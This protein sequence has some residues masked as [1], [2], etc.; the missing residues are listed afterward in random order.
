MQIN[1]AIS[2][3]ILVSVH[4]SKP[5]IVQRRHNKENS[6]DERGKQ[7]YLKCKPLFNH[8][9]FLSTWEPNWSC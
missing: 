3:D 4:W 6:N 9:I 1:R 2:A 5:L 7:V 8:E